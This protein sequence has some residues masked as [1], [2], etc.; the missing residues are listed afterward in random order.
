MLESRRTAENVIERPRHE[1]EIMALYGRAVSLHDAISIL[2]K[3]EHPEEAFMLSRALFSESLR[4][5]HLADA[6]EEGRVALVTGWIVDSVT[7][8]EEVQ[9][10]IERRHTGPE[11]PEF[12]EKASEMK[13]RALGLH[14]QEER[15]GRE[16]VSREAG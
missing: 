8:F 7:A 15:Q 4:L 16:E 9:R 13:R 3:R 5:R 1:G 14:A 11:S 2:L 12:S 6:T 10:D